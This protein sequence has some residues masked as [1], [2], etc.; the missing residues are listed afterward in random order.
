MAKL[1][2]YEA[3]TEQNLAEP[4]IERNVKHELGEELLKELRCNS[5]SGRVEE[6]VVG[7]IA[8]ILD[9]LD[10]I[11]VTGM[12]PF[13][14]RMNEEDGKINTWE[15]LDLLNENNDVGGVFSGI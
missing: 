14:L 4:S 3:R 6:D 12:D 13:Q 7:H 15:E 11:E 2:L 1:I 5:Y 8:K 9:I 10:P